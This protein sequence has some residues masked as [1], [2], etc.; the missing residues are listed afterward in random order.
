MVQVDR[1]GHR[2]AQKYQTSRSTMKINEYMAFKNVTYYLYV[3]HSPCI[4]NT[5]ANGAI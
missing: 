5:H 1:S 2:G 3:L 4:Y